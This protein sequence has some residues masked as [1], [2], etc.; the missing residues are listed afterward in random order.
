MKKLLLNK[1]NWVLILSAWTA[2]VGTN[3]SGITHVVKNRSICAYHHVTDTWAEIDDED[4]TCYRNTMLTRAG[5]DK[6]GG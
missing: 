4:S 5:E 6:D 2:V 1:M 3:W